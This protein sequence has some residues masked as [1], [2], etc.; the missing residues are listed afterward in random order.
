MEKPDNEGSC[1]HTYAYIYG[2]NRK[3]RGYLSINSTDRKNNSETVDRFDFFLYNKDRRLKRRRA[4]VAEL[5]Y[6][7]V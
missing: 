6:A 4:V 7:H 3:A 2:K 1:A 5:A